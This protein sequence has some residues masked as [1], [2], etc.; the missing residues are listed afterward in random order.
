MKKCYQRFG[1]KIPCQQLHVKGVEK[2]CIT[3]S[4]KGKE[5]AIPLYGWPGPW[6]S[7]R[8]RTPEQ[9]AHE[10]RKAVSPMHQPPQGYSMAGRIKS[11]KNLNDP[12]GNRTRDLPACSAV[13][14]PAVPPCTPQRFSAGGGGGGGGEEKKKKEKEKEI[15]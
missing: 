5:K 11:M 2:C 9:P 6:D 12:N 14:Y 8:L 4:V 1:N 10:G 7:R 15:K 3:D 13:S